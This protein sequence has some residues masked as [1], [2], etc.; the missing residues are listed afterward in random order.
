MEKGIIA[1]VYSKTDLMLADP[2]K[3][4]YR[5]KNLRTK[6][7]RFIGTR[8]YPPADD[9]VFKLYNSEVLDIRGKTVATY[10][11]PAHC[12]QQGNNYV[13]IKIN[14]YKAKF[15][16]AHLVVQVVETDAILGQRVLKD[17]MM[18]LVNKP[19]QLINHIANSSQE[20]LIGLINEQWAN[21]FM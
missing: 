10:C 18:E 7:D 8:F 19:I 21:V 16:V 14:W 17:N 1:I 2:N 12:S 6:I 5:G 3:K 9:A 15:M 20:I 13:V 4:P 11:N